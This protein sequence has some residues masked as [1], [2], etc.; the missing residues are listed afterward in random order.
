MDENNSLAI[1]TPEQA[2]MTAVVI[3]Q[4]MGPVMTEMTKLLRNN[5]EALNQLAAAQQIQADRLE[6]MERQIR[7]NT[8]VTPQQVKYINDAIRA[9][10]RELLLKREVEDE[11]AV[12]KLGNMIRKGVLSRYGIGA[13][14]EIPKH[15][16]SVT[17]N[18]IGT[19]ND[20]L[21]VRDV[22]KEARMREEEAKKTALADSEQAAGGNG[23]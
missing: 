14:H 16:Y 4:I 19:W 8:L 17:M 10:A 18:H 15:E 6:A 23:L 20:M 5:T 3:Q 2:Q 12:R 21:C 22:V 11:R 1:L 13:V 7:L 9:R